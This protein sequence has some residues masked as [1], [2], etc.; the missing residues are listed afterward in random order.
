MNI[1][2]KLVVGFSAIIT[3][4]LI[5]AAIYSM[6]L[7]RGLAVENVYS[8]TAK[9]VESYSEKLDG[10]LGEKKAI[11]ESTA[12]TVAE[13]GKTTGNMFQSYKLRPDEINDLY[14]GFEDG[15]FVDGSG[16]IPEKDFKTTERP[17]Y[18]KAKKENKFVFSAPY[19]D[20]QTKELVVSPATPIISA[21]KFIGVIAADIK[22]TALLKM[23]GEINLFKGKGLGILID[24]EG[25]VLAHYKQDN[26]SKNI[27]EISEFKDYASDIL[28]KHE[29]FYK[30]KEDGIKKIMFFHKISI[31][32]WTLIITVPQSTVYEKSDSVILGF[33]ILFAVILAVGIA[34][35]SLIAKNILKPIKDFSA[36]SNDLS[37]G[38]LRVRVDENRNDEIGDMSKNMNNFL[39]VMGAMLN[40]IKEYSVSLAERTRHI[41][42]TMNEIDNSLG[43]LTNSSNTTAASV[44]EMAVT[45]DSVAQNVENLLKN[46][47]QTLTSAYNGGNLVNVTIEGINKIKS[48][49]EQGKKNVKDLGIKTDEIGEIVN[50]I[51]EIAA[52]TNLLAL[53]AAIE[54]A[55]AGEAGKGFEVVA[56]EVRKLAEKTTMSTKEIAKMVK[57]IQGETSRVIVNMD[58]V[59]SEVVEG[60]KNVSET[61]KALEE[62]VKQTKNL[63]DM[64]DMIATATK[65]QSIVANQIAKE[66][67]TITVNVE[68]N[69]TSIEES[70]E[71]IKEITDIA[72]R[73]NDIVKQFKTLEDKSESKSIKDYNE[74]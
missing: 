24:N 22:L 15:Y 30:I 68:E 42:L 23:V 51:N 21:G 9:S 19:I 56:E 70:G 60:V 50:V 44:E 35:V 3:V 26:I 20:V 65:E 61:G 27:N 62:I 63:R 10:W 7:V 5:L 52:Q 13:S 64:V 40:R 53:N 55:R 36:V 16:W 58:E 67:E 29:G 73:L 49:A 38:D 74:D 43:N 37:E 59:N 2:T 18:I 69:S 34:L 47:E 33:I 31:T 71:A 1:R 12:V 4:T 6:V 46:S 41:S 48:V 45:T 39:N 14:A 11:V 57:E 28:S 25:F 54:A 17:W 8:I 32:N 72:E 66:T